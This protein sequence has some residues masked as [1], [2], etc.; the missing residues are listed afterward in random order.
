MPEAGR[1]Q[2]RDQ[3]IDPAIIEMLRQRLAGG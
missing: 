2:C 1:R 3:A